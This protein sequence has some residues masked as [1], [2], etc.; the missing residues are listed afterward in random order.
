MPITQNRMLMLIAAT[1]E[2]EDA[3]TNFG[4]I[5]IDFIRQAARGEITLGELE[6]NISRTLH[7]LRPS[8]E[9]IRAIA[10]EKE[11]FR[12]SASKN[13]YAAKRMKQVR[14]AD[15]MGT[16]RPVNEPIVSRASIARTDEA[17]AKAGLPPYRPA[18]FPPAQHFTSAEIERIRQTQYEEELE[19]AL[20]VTRKAT[21]AGGNE[22]TVVIEKDP[23]AYDPLKPDSPDEDTF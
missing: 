14:E 5:A 4:Q 6:G 16:P 23:E 18:G 12:L 19:N 11:H 15:K 9:A 13:V 1:A 3:F 8:L 17:N 10:K 20:R 2:Y 21:L 7:E 22:A